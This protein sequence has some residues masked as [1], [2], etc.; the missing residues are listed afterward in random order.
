[1]SKLVSL[2]CEGG[3][4]ELEINRPER[5][6]SLI[7]ELLEEMLAALA[8]VEARPELRALILCARGASFSTGGDVAAFLAH[9]D[10]IESYSRRIV[11]A[12]NRVVL[13]L[14]RLRVPVIAAAQGWTTGGSLGLLLGADLVVL[15]EDARFAPF[16]T[17]VG[18]SPDGGWA[19]LLPRLI[20]VRAAAEVQYLNRPFRA[21]EA[22]RWGLA[23]KVVPLAQLREEARALA[24]QIAAMVP[25]S[26]TS[27][28]RLLRADLKEWETALAAEL[29]AFVSCIQSPAVRESAQAFVAQLGRK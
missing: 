9:W 6:N 17:R 13:A 12:L 16:Y 28:K 4:A 14:A 22:L 21:E 19:V 10:R 8:E 29:E 5:H 15:A 23:N 2:T 27:T 20:G 3:V 26:V 25:E 18:F 1:M 7:P 24:G 11:G